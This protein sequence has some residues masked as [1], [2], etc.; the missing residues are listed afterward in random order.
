MIHDHCLA[1]T[2]VRKA[3]RYNSGVC[4]VS[5]RV[6]RSKRGYYTHALVPAQKSFN[7][8]Q[9][10][11][12]AIYCCDIHTVSSQLLGAE[13]TQ[14]G[15]RQRCLCGNRSSVS[16]VSWRKMRQQGFHPTSTSLQQHER[17]DTLP[18]A[19]SGRRGCRRC[20][21]SQLSRWSGW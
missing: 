8:D 9:C 2:G 10:S 19:S 7:G 15:Q 21:T 1:P 17:T 5:S 12:A 4:G 16:S 6:A 11:T 18:R 13:F 14:S 20:T 3:A